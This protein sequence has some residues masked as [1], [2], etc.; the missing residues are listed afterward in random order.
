MLYADDTVLYSFNK[1]PKT[2]RDIVQLN[3]NKLA[4]WCHLNKLTINEKKTKSMIFGTTQMIREAKLANI[5]LDNTV[6][7]FVPDY[8]YLGMKL[9]Q[10]LTF[11]LHKTETIKLMSH[12]I[13]LLA[14]IRH[15]SSLDQALMIY[16]TKILPYAEYGDILIADTNQ[17]SLD[18]IQRLQNRALRIALKSEA[19]TS[20]KAIHKTAKINMLYE[21]R[22]VHIRNVA[23]QRKSNP[24]YIRNPTRYTRLFDGVVFSEILSKRNASKRSV[25]S[26]CAKY[27]NMLKPEVRNTPTL[28]AFKKKQIYELKLLRENY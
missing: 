10:K 6:I 5:K 4:T 8:N 25:Y 26:K 9:D 15:L 3:L 13:F 17:Y 14:K 7:S 16:K 24:R 12:K 1:N 11:E 21:R 22:I 23:F 27:W 28:S 20:V 19:M 18:K 2:A